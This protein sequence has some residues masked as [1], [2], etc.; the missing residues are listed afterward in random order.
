M[1]LD[2]LLVQ[3]VLHGFIFTGVTTGKNFV[4]KFKMPVW[5]K[6]D[7]HI[8]IVS[9]VGL[10]WSILYSFLVAGHTK[11]F[12]TGALAWLS[13]QSARLSFQTCLSWLIQ[14]ATQV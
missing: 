13:R 12:L 10:H 4:S 6:S 1:L 14:L 3:N 11:F 5:K 9:I 2:L 8:E 7:V